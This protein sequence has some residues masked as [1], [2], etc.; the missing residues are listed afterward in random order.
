MLS[1]SV[2]GV[3]QQFF[4]ALALRWRSARPLFTTSV[5]MAGATA[6]AMYYHIAAI[7]PLIGASPNLKVV[8]LGY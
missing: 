2:S 8:D 4:R 6:H 3:K 5:Y 1:Q 7:D